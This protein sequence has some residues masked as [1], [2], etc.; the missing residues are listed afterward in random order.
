MPW[1]FPKK[2]GEEVWGQDWVAGGSGLGWGWERIWYGAGI[3][4]RSSSGG[5]LAVSGVGFG[6]EDSWV[7][8]QIRIGDGVITEARDRARIGG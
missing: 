6:E 2:G 7:W 8:G 5:V 3:K 1:C 4:L